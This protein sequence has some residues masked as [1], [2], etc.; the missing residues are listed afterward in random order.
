M[1]KNKIIRKIKNAIEINPILRKIFDLIGENYFYKKLVYLIINQVENKI[2]KEKKYNI[3]IE[4]T[5]LCNARCVMCP[6]LFMKRK[7]EIMKDSIFLKILEKIKKEKI[8]PQV[9]IINGFGE[10]L[11]DKKIFERIKTLKNFF[12]NIPVKFYS[13]FNLAN[14]Y[15]IREIFES[16]VD[17]INISF[18]G[19][20]KK[21]YTQT[22][23]L[24][25]LKTIKNL[26]KLI[27]EKRKRRSQIPVIRISMTLVK[28]NEGE[29]RKFIE[30]WERLVDSVS[31]NRVHN[32]GGAVEDVSGSYKINYNKTPYPCKY[33]WNTI[34][35]GVKGDIFLCCLDYEG[36]YVFG[37]IL[38][39]GI[40]ESFYSKKFQRIRELH[41]KGEIKKLPLCSFYYTPYRNGV[42]WFFDKLF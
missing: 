11:T 21:S 32:Y 41:L 23:G 37:N 40:L 13:N 42:E 18:N 2:K 24:N 20:N 27:A 12:P 9:F 36:K 25:Y 3:I 19:L 15:I 8:N 17:E 31:V 28:T 30:K 39:N 6:H 29:E 22:M 35:F 26:K 5:N 14:D 34:V 16:K 10:P 38:K 1:L 4:T 7:K 33:I